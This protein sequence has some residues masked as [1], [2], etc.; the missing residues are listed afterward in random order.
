MGRY[1]AFVRSYASFPPVFTVH[2]F[3]CSAQRLV[4][5][6]SVKTTGAV[7]QKGFD[8][9]KKRVKRQIVTEDIGC[10]LYVLIHKANQH[11]TKMGYWVAC[12]STFAYPT[13]QKI[14]GDGGYRCSFVYE[15]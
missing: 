5:Q 3:T 9:E 2:S 4:G 7:E 8:A 15:A 1:R 12:L 6:K 11:D 14:C 10:L 13:L